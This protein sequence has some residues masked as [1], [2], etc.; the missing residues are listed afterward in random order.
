MANIFEKGAK[1]LGG[2]YDDVSHFITGTPKGQVQVAPPNYDAY[3][4]ELGA[5]PTERALMQQGYGMMRGLQQD[6]GDT[7]QIR[8]SG[9][10]DPHMLANARRR[11]NA[12][13]ETAGLP[14]VGFDPGEAGALADSQRPTGRIA[15]DMPRGGLM[16]S[17]G[18]GTPAKRPSDLDVAARDTSAA[19]KRFATRARDEQAIKSVDRKKGG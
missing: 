13:Y 7:P 2:A 4:Y 12:Q 15:D 10:G 11:R 3:R 19:D 18:Y 8:L 6:Y 9:Q 17:A 16:R 1:W 5:D 14:G